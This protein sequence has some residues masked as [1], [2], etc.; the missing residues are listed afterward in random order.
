MGIWSFQV[1]RVVVGVELPYK[2]LNIDKDPGQLPAVATTSW[3]LYQPRPKPGMMPGE[4]P[5][6]EDTNK[7][8]DMRLL[9]FQKRTL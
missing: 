3:S 8:Q 7:S 6:C 4:H 9:M 5:T 2:E 1:G